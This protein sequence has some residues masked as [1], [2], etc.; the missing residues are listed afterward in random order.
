MKI[1]VLYKLNVALLPVFFC[2][3]FAKNLAGLTKQAWQWSWSE[4]HDAYW[5]NRRAYNIGGGK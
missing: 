3:C 2:I 5:A 1:W 4:T